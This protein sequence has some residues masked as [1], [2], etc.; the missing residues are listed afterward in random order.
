MI[1]LG[2][3]QYGL[4]PSRE[5]FVSH[6]IK[7]T[8]N[9]E[10][11][12]RPLLAWK[13]RVGQLKRVPADQSIGYGCTYRT[14][15]DSRIAVVPV[16]YADGYD[17]ALGNQAYVLVRGRRAPVRGRVCMNN[18]M[19]DVTDIPE[20]MLEDQVVLIGRQGADEIRVDLMDR[21]ET[22]EPPSADSMESLVAGEDVSAEDVRE[23]LEAIRHCYSCGLCDGCD[24]QRSPECDLLKR[25]MYLCAEKPQ[26]Q[27]SHIGIPLILLIYVH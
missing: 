18:I 24:G 23:V 16:G 5:T 9:G 11:V 7:H 1:R 21:S 26:Q 20:V 17:R 2:I 6:K 12:L 15:R 14:T 13:T 4:W 10:D 19:V 27:S 22:L 8:R 3:S 25:W